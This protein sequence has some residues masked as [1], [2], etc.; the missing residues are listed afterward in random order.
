MSATVSAMTITAAQAAAVLALCI[1][2]PVYFRRSKPN[3][4]PPGPPSIP[5]SATSTNCTEWASC[6]GDV[7]YAQ[8]LTGS[9]SIV[10]SAN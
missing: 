2:C 1:L 6:Y 10:R 7:V 8:F 3:D 5:Y 9:V 4:L